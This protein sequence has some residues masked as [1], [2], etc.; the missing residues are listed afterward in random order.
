MKPTIAIIG[1]KGRMATFLAQQ[2]T[3][4]QCAEHIIAMDKGDTLDKAGEADIIILAVP[5]S[6]M[7]E[8]IGSLGLVVKKRQLVVDI[9]S[10]KGSFVKRLKELQC[11]VASVH[12]LFGNHV[13]GFQGQNV[14]IMSDV[15]TKKDQ[16]MLEGLFPH[17]KIS[18]FTVKEHD[19]GMKYSLC[20]PFILRKIF[21]KITKT[22]HVG[23][24]STPSYRLFEKYAQHIKDDPLEAKVVEEILNANQEMIME[25]IEEIKKS[26]KTIEGELK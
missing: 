10:T 16:Q 14:A 13:Q 7:N 2:W 12:P 15:G 26:L 22:A 6:A 11:K 19:E 21:V 23:K 5:L 20:L 3:W 9:G 24:L 1:G 4:N 18:Y 25:L 17:S 8:V